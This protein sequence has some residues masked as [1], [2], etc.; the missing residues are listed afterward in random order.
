MDINQDFQDLLS[1]IRDAYH[2]DVKRANKDKYRKPK[3]T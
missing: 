2:L 1:M 3:F